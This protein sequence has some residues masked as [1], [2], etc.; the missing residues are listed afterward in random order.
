MNLLFY[1]RAY[2]NVAGGVE[3][4]SLDLARGLV[5][6][7]HTITVLSLDQELDKSFFPWPEKVS[8]IKLG[9]GNPNKKNNIFIRLRRVLTIR[10]IARNG[11]FDSAVGFQIGSF[12]L[13][14]S[15]LVGL[16]I[17]TIAAE[18]NAPTLFKYISNGKFKRFFSNL[19][20]Y[21][22]DC[23]TVQ[24]E[25]YRK[26]YPRFLQNKIKV[27]PNW[28]ATQINISRTLDPEVINI[29]FIGR[30]TFQKNASVLIK[31]LKYLPTNFQLSIVGDGPEIEWLKKFSSDFPQR[32][33][34]YAPSTDLS[35]LYRGANVFCLTSRWEGFPNVIAEALSYGLPC[36]GFRECSGIP[37]LLHD[38]QNGFTANKMGD[39]KSLAVAL[40]AAS[41]IK[42]S[43]ADI[44]LTVENYT[45]ENY[46]KAWEVALS[47]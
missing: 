18:R 24:F 25:D 20:L 26:L 43:P 28:V 32:V 45:Y 5:E 12:A 34:F 46:I 7:G 36:V 40:M 30:L 42:S 23:I 13:L 16:G 27:T 11:N 4:M 35:V 19:I 17:R 39:P 47:Q 3:K 14:K 1:S 37:Q 41:H 21:S 33:E 10:S 8:W 9:I 22:A 2:A 15:A 38:N 44:A 29:L 6:R 31:A